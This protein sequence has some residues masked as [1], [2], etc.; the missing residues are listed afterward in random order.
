[1]SVYNIAGNTNTTVY[2]LDGGRALRGHNVDGTV[3]LNSASDILN[4]F[5][6]LGD[7]YSTFAGHLTPDTNSSWYPTDGTY[8]DGN[9]V[10]TV[11]QT[12]WYMFKEQYALPLT[13]NNSHSGST[14]SYDGYGDGTVDGKTTS[15]IQRAGSLGSPGLIFVFGGTNDAWV[16]AELGEYKYTDITEADLSYFRPALAYLLDNIKSQHPSATVVFIL[17]H[18]ITPSFKESVKTIC[19]H[20]SVPC[21]EL[22]NIAMTGG[23]PN[24]TGMVTLSNQVI[25]FMD[26]LS[27]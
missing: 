7:S 23:H 15:F 27:V 16:P 8:G 1:M 9:D 17:N 4:S 13:I 25:N 3:V 10:T 5:S 26:K 12:W 21:V 6:I 18:A 11:E 19:E 14:V 24:S 20:M 22:N 2:H